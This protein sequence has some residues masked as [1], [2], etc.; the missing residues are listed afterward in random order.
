MLYT[1]DASLVSFKAWSGAEHTLHT[2][3]IDQI[4]DIE[5]I[6]SDVWSDSIP[7]ATDINDFL[8][9][10]RDTIAEWLGFTDWEEL[11]EYNDSQA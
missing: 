1:V 8:W 4:G 9:F 3:T 10:E 7:T 2:L 5:D 11:E 6:L